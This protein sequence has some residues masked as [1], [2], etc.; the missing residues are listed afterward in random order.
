MSDKQVKL[1]Y[2]QEQINQLFEHG[3]NVY[4]VQ[5]KQPGDNTFG[6]QVYAQ[7][8]D[9]STRKMGP[10][11]SLL[12]LNDGFNSALLD[13]NCT[14]FSLNRI[15]QNE[16][17][18]AVTIEKQNG[19][20]GNKLGNQMLMCVVN[21]KGLRDKLISRLHEA[22]PTL[23]EEQLIV[24]GEDAF[25]ILDQIDENQDSPNRMLDLFEAQWVRIYDALGREAPAKPEN[26]LFIVVAPHPKGL[27]NQVSKSSTSNKPIP[28]GTNER[29]GF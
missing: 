29:L 3:V 14:L 23:K 7:L 25:K 6:A 21:S 8:R 5:N 2:A 4:D 9:L 15:E 20:L 22:V 27:Y 11:S 24:K 12:I 1:T 28:T 13:S 26:I 18:E 10:K 19:T 17:G 16:E